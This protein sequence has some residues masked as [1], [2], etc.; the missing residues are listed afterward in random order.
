MYIS[1]NSVGSSLKNGC[2]W[3]KHVMQKNYFLLKICYTDGTL[4][5]CSTDTT[6][7]GYK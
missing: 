7:E 2:L 3:L 6:E 5:L 4:V 1:C